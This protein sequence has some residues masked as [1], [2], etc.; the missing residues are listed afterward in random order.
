MTALPALAIEATTSAPTPVLTST[1]LF[2]PRLR[3]NLV[4]RS[5][6]ITRL[7]DDPERR[8]TVITAP[9]GYGKT[10]L[11]AQLVAR[12]A[13]PTAWVRL[14]AADDSPRS[15]FELVLA[16]LHLIDRDLAAGTATL[17][18]QDGPDAEEIV[19][20]LIEDL[21]VTTRSFVLVLDDYHVIEAPEIHQAMDLLLRRLP[22]ATRLM[23]ISRT[24]PPLR[25]ARLRTSGEL[26]LVAQSELQFT[27]EETLQYFHDSLDLD[28][29]PSE[30]G[31]I[32][33]RTEGWVIGLQLVGSALHGR[34]REQTRQF[35]QEFVGSVELGDQY[36][37]E[38]VLERQPEE[39]R[40]FLLRTAV[41]DRFNA[42][43][44]DAVTQAGT[45]DEL[46]RHCERNNLF[47]LP[48]A[49]QGAWYRYHHL[50]A[51][52]LREQLGRTV[53]EEEITAL[54]RRAAT[55]LEA[56]GHFEDAIR[57]AT[58]GR[59]WDHVIEMLEAVC[60]ELF[61]R[62]QIATL[63][64]WLQGIPPHVLATSPR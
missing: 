9:A 53:S 15:F 61:E 57:H 56:N 3:T 49:G 37:W 6:L 29:T 45:S 63:R 52:A 18:T 1:R 19:Q 41:L 7:S 4:E 20:Q 2:P 39:V 60:A 58:A 55:W 48:L 43:L 38:E 33:E 40:D 42:S 17:L 8:L 16:A 62:D 13:L 30:V 31:V 32:H 36:L 25:L 12:L 47:I 59:Q 21:S 44:C 46:L 50:F 28:L 64:H 26:L 22:T 5:S 35:L 23:L 11:A 24:T 51:D 34:T 14:E 27:L 54:H 10:T